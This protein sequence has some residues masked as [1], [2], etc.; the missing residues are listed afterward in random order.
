MRHL[1]VSK[2]L[3]ARMRAYY[4]LCFP[5]RAMFDETSIISSLSHPLQS[6]IALHKCHGVLESLRV[7][8][9]P[10]LARVIA[11]LLERMVFVHDDYIIYA[12]Q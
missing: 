5:G 3:R 2:E 1:H 7:L 10:Q 9:E 12:G 8:H 6:E 4:E 11:S